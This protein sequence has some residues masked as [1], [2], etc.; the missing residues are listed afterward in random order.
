MLKISTFNQ[1]QLSINSLNP[2][3]IYTVV[4]DVNTMKNPNPIFNPKQITQIAPNIKIYPVLYKLGELI[5]VQDPNMTNL[6]FMTVDALFQKW[7]QLGYN[8]RN[9]KS[10][11]SS[12]VFQKYLDDIDYTSADYIIT[13]F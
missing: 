6:R 7:T 9:A 5:D 8:T 13:Q 11:F 2:M 12:R 4:D 10:P 1:N 3:D